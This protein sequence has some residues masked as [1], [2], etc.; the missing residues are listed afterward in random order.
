MN[1]K[2]MS[3][4]EIREE[5]ERAFKL[6]KWGPTPGQVKS[7]LRLVWWDEMRGKL[8]ALG[9]WKVEVTWG[10]VE[11]VLEGR[12]VVEQALREWARGERKVRG[13]KKVKREEK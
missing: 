7:Q 9:G 8:V 1:R 13:R 6:S 10:G 11:E 2:G 12:R 3:E 4:D 5:V